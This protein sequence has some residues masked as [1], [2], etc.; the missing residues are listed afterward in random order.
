M[1][2]ETIETE[3]PLEITPPRLRIA[4]VK[5]EAAREF[6]LTPGQ[7]EGRRQFADSSAAR[8]VC[9][10]ILRNYKEPPTPM[11]QLAREFGGRHHTTILAGVESISRRLAKDRKLR[12]RA[13]KILDRLQLALPNSEMVDG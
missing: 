12:R 7:I 4:E 2:D 6:N 8:Q 1:S 11:Q 10:W 3:A 5:T 13:D 9:W